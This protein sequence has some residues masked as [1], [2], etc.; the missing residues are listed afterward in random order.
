MRRATRTHRYRAALR[1]WLKWTP[2]L[3]MPFSVLFVETQLHVKIL[4]KDYEI[5]AV[6]RQIRACEQAIEQLE[7]EELK[8]KAMDRMAAK[9][10]EL[11]LVEPEVN[12]IQVVRREAPEDSAP[13]ARPDMALA[14]LARP[15]E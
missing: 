12:Q 10:L 4:A 1:G 2:F 14:S 7:E 15:F 9:A 6:K 13:I 8:L 3:V 11:N 5:S